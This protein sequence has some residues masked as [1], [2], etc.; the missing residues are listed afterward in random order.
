MLLLLQH[1]RTR[2]SKWHSL[3]CNDH[4]Q[5]NM[6]HTADSWLHYTRSNT[7]TLFSIQLITSLTDTHTY[8]HTETTTVTSLKPDSVTVNNTT[9]QQGRVN[10]HDNTCLTNVLS[11]QSPVTWIWLYN[12]RMRVRNDIEALHQPRLTNLRSLHGWVLP[13]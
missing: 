1:Y 7:V 3:D 8:I 5:C 11:Q 4:Q 2:P 10:K 12:K 9:S 13:P 6:D